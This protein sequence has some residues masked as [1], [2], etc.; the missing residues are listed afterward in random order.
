MTLMKNTNEFGFGAWQSV[1]QGY[2][3]QPAQEAAHVEKL[4]KTIAQ[5]QLEMWG[6]ASRRAR[7]M[8]A[9]PADLVQCRTPEAIGRVQAQYW[10]TAF[11][12]Y[13]DASGRMAEVMSMATGLAHPAAPRIV[14]DTNPPVAAPAAAEHRERDY[15][16]VPAAVNGSKDRARRPA[17]TGASEAHQPERVVA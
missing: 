5:C 14:Q 1:W 8:L 3:A 7:A 4:G 12:H 16:S 13:A 9:L 6:L 17:A 2:F 11:E 10:A 15:I